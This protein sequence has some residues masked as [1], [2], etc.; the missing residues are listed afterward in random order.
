MNLE[1][2]MYDSRLH[3]RRSLNVTLDVKNAIDNDALPKLALHDMMRRLDA[4]KNEL[5][6]DEKNVMWLDKEEITSSLIEMSILYGILCK[7]TAFS[8]ELVEV[9]DVKQN[10][11]RTRV[12]VPSILSQDYL[13]KGS[14]IHEPQYRAITGK[15]G[16]HGSAKTIYEPMRPDGGKLKKSEFVETNDKKNDDDDLD[17]DCLSQGPLYLRAIMK[18]NLDGC[19][20]A[21]DKDLQ[22]LMFNSCD[23]P[24]MPQDLQGDVKNIWMT[25]LVLVWLEVVCQENQKAWKLVY[26][27]GYDWLRNQKVDF[28]NLKDFVSKNVLFVKP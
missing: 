11:K 8:C 15:P 25:I 2:Q 19:F 10:L 23:L 3:K 5:I 20:D 21:N 17:L 22:K 6:G 12:V 14:Q 18:Q 4:E 24:S 27:K 1:L 7:E 16:K 26:Q 28:I 9:Y 13:Y